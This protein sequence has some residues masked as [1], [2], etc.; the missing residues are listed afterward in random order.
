MSG[1][2]DLKRFSEAIIEIVNRSTEISEIMK[3]CEEDFERVRSEVAEAYKEYAEAL[4]T[5][6][7]ARISAAKAKWNELRAQMR[8]MYNAISLE[9]E[10][11]FFPR[12]G[13]SQAEKP[14][15]VAPTHE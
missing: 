13:I 2:A 9:V 14:E 4:K 5:C 12:S 3:R 7:E 10:K 1:K 8:D 11:A 15:S 6:D